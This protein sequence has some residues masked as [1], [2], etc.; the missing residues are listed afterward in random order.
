MH[1]VEA[2]RLV[3][4]RV[5]GPKPTDQPLQLSERGRL[6][7][8]VIRAQGECPLRDLFEIGGA[9]DDDFQARL[10]LLVLLERINAGE[11]GH[12]EIEHDDIG[13]E[14]IQECE[15][16]RAPRDPTHI[17]A[18]QRKKPDEHFADLFLVI[19]DEQSSGRCGRSGWCAGHACGGIMPGSVLAIKSATR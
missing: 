18:F 3:S 11:A 13:R 8:I 4:M 12:E 7:D 17:V 1:S 19:N 6:A 9:E 15:R 16:L 14:D 10:A 5:G 2:C